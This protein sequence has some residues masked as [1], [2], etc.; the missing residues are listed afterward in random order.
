M[1]A[2]SYDYTASSYRIRCLGCGTQVHTQ[3]P[4][5][6]EAVT[7]VGE[8]V[9]ATFPWYCRGAFSTRCRVCTRERNRAA[10][11][12]RGN[13]TVATT[14]GLGVGRRF[15]VE[16]ELIFPSG[17][18]NAQIQ[19]A[20]R[21]AGLSGWNAVY[22]CSLRAE[23]TYRGGV[24]WEIVSPILAGENGIEQIRTA[25]RVLRDLGAKPNKSCGMHVHHEVVDL[26]LDGI[27]RLYRS[28]A[29]NQS[30]IDGLVAP[31]R[32]GGAR[33]SRFCRG[34]DES[35]AR[36]VEAARDLRSI[37][38]GGKFKALNLSYVGSRGTIEIRQH[39][40]TCDPEKVVSWVRFGQGL[41]DAAAEGVVVDRASR[42]RDFLGSL[43]ERLD[44]TA[45]TYLLGR[46]VEFG[47]VAA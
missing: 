16:M 15:G 19:S 42:M 30:T 23:S 25:T 32:R 11:G 43:G 9:D 10:R 13:R 4:Y 27:K 31:S 45:R 39:Q 17:T 28:W 47:A 33:E 12:S 6:R 35:E 14:R 41:V 24:G 34:V 7:L 8:R 44:E 26:G 3:T 36:T 20:L 40:G 29:N 5:N 22:D 46:T 18:S 37:R 38:H 1:P 2:T 21:A